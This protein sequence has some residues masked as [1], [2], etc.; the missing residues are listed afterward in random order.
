MSTAATAPTATATS[1]AATGDG[2]SPAIRFA[3]APFTKPAIGQL[4]LDDLRR[5]PPLDEPDF[6]DDDPPPPL[7]DPRLRLRPDG[8]ERE[9]PEEFP[10]P[11]P[12]EEPLRLRED[13]LFD[14]PLFEEPPPLRD[15]VRSAWRLKRC[16]RE[17]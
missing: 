3:T 17:R 10:P 7:L 5:D 6:F 1:A 2:R 9:P 16:E 8:C 14:E 11:L 12:E 15:D 4:R 13:P